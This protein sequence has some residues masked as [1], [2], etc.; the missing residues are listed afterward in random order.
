MKGSPVQYFDDELAWIEANATL[1]RKEMHGAFVARFE[2]PDV[3]L[4]QLNALCK[5]KGWM[6]GRTGRIEPG[7]TPPNKGR[8]M[9]A[10]VREKCLKTAF[11]PGNRPHNTKGHGHER[12]DS[13]DG[14]VV[15]IVDEVNPW[16]GHKTRPIHK[17]RYLWEQVNGPIPEGHAL[18]CLDGDKTNCDPSNWELIPRGMLPHLNGKGARLKYDHAPAE[19]KPTLMGIARLKHALRQRRSTPLDQSPNPTP[20]KIPT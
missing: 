16:N 1:P 5:R 11:R 4:S 10:H 15:M 14:Y 12:I 6:T 2:R 9:P 13:K 20:R 18:K 3:T 7:A 8:P 17:H 19:I